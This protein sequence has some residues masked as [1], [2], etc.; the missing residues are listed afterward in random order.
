MMR[1]IAAWMLTVSLV[2]NLLPVWAVATNQKGFIGV[3][4][5]PE[6][7]AVE[8]AT[9]EDLDRMRDNLSGSYVLVNDIDLS[10]YGDWSPIGFTT[11]SGFRGT[12][13]GQG[14]KITGLNVSSIFTSATLL[15]PNYAVGLFGVCEGAT[16]KNLTLENV[17][18]SVTTKSGYGYSSSIAGSKNSV[19]AGA[20]A[21]FLTGNCQIYNCYTSGTVQAYAYEEG[22]SDALAGGIAGYMDGSALRC[23]SSSCAVNAL[24]DNAVQA[25]NAVAGGLFGAVGND[26]SLDRSSNSGTVKAQA[27]N[28]GNAY[29]GGLV[30]YNQTTTARIS[31]SYN[32]GAI[33]SITGGFSGNIFCDDAY[34]GGIAGFYSGLLADCYN[35]ATVQAQTNDDLGIS[36]ASTFAGGIGGSASAEAVISGCANVISSVSA[37]GKKVQFCSIACGGTKMNNAA[38]EQSASGVQ[39]DA[40][41]MISS[42][43]AKMQTLYED[44]LE[45]DFSSVWEMVSGKDF[46]QLKQ[47]ADS[48]TGEE[49]YWQWNLENGLLVLFGDGP[50]PDWTSQLEI[51]WHDRILEITEVRIADGIT[52]VGDYAFYECVN[53]QK[54]TVGTSVAR[55]GNHAFTRC[56]SLRGLELPASVKEIGAYAFSNAGLTDMVF[57]GGAPDIGFS[58]WENVQTVV[59][60]YSNRGNWTAVIE[61]QYGGSL[62][63]T[64][65]YQ[66]Q[67]SLLDV[68]SVNLNYHTAEDPIFWE[69]KSLPGVPSNVVNQYAEELFQWAKQCGRETILTKTVCE[70]IVR[71]YIPTVVY[72]EEGVALTEDQYKTWEIMRDVLM[73]NSAKKSI[74]QWEDE[75]LK[76]VASVDLMAAQQKLS[77]ILSIYASYTEELERNPL[78]NALYNIYALPLVQKVGNQVWKVSKKN[79]IGDI[80][81]DLYAGDFQS[82]ALQGQQICV[83]WKEDG[84]DSVIASGMGIGKDI[85]EDLKKNGIKNLAKDQVEQYIGRIIDQNPTLKDLHELESEI[86]SYAK[87]YKTYSAVLEFAPSTM[88]MIVLLEQGKKIIDT[89]DQSKEAQ[90]FMLQYDTLRNHREAY[91]YIVQEDGGIID[92]VDLHMLVADGTITLTAQQETLLNLWY[93]RGNQALVEQEKRILLSSLASTAVTLQ[94]MTPAAMRDRI[95]E[96]WV[97]ELQKEENGDNVYQI[98]YTLDGQ[99]AFQVMKGGADIVG[100]YAPDTGYVSAASEM[101]VARAERVSSAE[102]VYVV[103]D[104]AGKYVTVA[105]RSSDYSIKMNTSASFALVDVLTEQNTG[106]AAL[107]QSPQQNYVLSVHNNEITAWNESGGVVTPVTVYEED[108]SIVTQDA[109]SLQIQYQGADTADRVVEDLILTQTGDLGSTITWSSSDEAV[110]SNAGAVKQAKNAQNVTLTAVLEKGNFRQEKTFSVLVPGTGDVLATWL[111]GNMLHYCID[112]TEGESATLVVA[113]YDE[114][115]RMLNAKVLENAEV[116]G[117]VQM[118][119]AGQYRVFLLKQGSWI[120]LCPA[121]TP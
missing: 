45:W 87:S 14:H 89:I 83:A 104:P 24:N 77:K 50:L 82:I 65:L 56:T 59:G 29:A 61:E 109:D 41:L 20:L 69:D 84:M 8:I 48:E 86:V 98:Q 92:I 18:V 108:E 36:N 73:I 46:P 106:Y 44:T 111:D 81:K 35:C 113:G 1:K 76:G 70:E 17:N 21:G 71:E 57:L 79:A 39:N 37:V 62:T 26:G 116:S 25:Q 2:M 58:A 6:A 23:S 34:A 105:V 78:A 32:E 88:L 7:G 101:L 9:A 115:G 99:S 107:Y 49:S 13:D 10:D 5:P 100:A 30:G 114:T 3:I 94:N 53:L 112:L 72:E 64:D 43:E 12:L 27:G 91:D 11:G 31:D 47:M 19:F 33:V 16:I 63:W 54:V 40:D 102:M 110:V 119:E 90:Y 68:S 103:A 85:L 55:V 22:Y 60:Y 75:Y 117:T 121:V 96:Y 4:D 66:E 120:P 74:N 118:Q 67:N 15:P 38:V 28:Y 80:Q 42:A 93:E 97:A 51:P 95:V 52:S